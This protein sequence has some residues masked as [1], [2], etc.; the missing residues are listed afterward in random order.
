MTV[1]SPPPSPTN[2]MFS[3]V[4]LRNMLQWLPGNGTPADTHYTV[5]YA[6]YGDSAEDG[7]G[8]RVHWR[9]VRQC[10]EI[11]RSWCDLSNETWDLEHGYYARIRAVSKRA[12]SK[13]TLTR[14]FDPKLDTTFGPPLISVEIESN[15]ATVT[16]EGPMRYQPNNHTPGVSMATLY[17]QMMYNLSI[18]NKYR[19]QMSHFLMISS[20]YKYKLMEYNTEYCFSAKT[21]FLSLPVHCGSSAWHCITTPP[22]PL[23]DH[24]KW[25]VVGIIVPFT[26]M[27]VL[28]VAS[29]LLYHYLSGKGQKSPNN[30][31]P[32]T[33]HGPPLTFPPE[34]PNFILITVM[35][36]SDTEGGLSDPVFPKQQRQIAGPALSYVPQGSESP[37]E[38]EESCDDVS[39]DYGFVAEAL[40]IHVRGGEE[41]RRWRHDG[42]DWNN[43]IGEN[44]SGV[45]RDRNEEK[46]QKVGSA[47][48]SQAQ[49]Y[50]S[51]RSGHT[52]T[53]THMLRDKQT[54][55]STLIRAQVFSD[56]APL[57]QTQEPFPSFQGEED[58]EKKDVDFP[59]LFSNKKPQI[60]SFHIPLNLQT[61]TEGGMNDETDRR[62]RGR[63]D[64]EIDGGVEERSEGEGV[65]LLSAYASQN[66]RDM[67]AFQSDLPP[68]DYGGLRLATADEIDYGDDDNEEE[69]E[70]WGGGIFIDWG[71]NMNKLVFKTAGSNEEEGTMGQREEDEAYE[72]RGKLTLENVFV[73]QASEEEAEAQRRL[74]RGGD[75][76]I[77]TKWN[78]VIP[79]D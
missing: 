53:Q 61:E 30:L 2:V 15:S 38:P 46:V 10:T 44:Q 56:P 45:A 72:K 8:R 17:P 77:F 48:A 75:E 57:T 66:I 37:P 42:E 6:I 3:S 68:N 31:N 34:K 23:I 13:W 70:E 76:D 43:P 19:D 21:K 7:K 69:E 27:C 16:L 24:L 9:A 49:C 63:A 79:T 55:I 73:R 41:G 58:E 47:R 18:H 51:Q 5:Q 40:N 11:T 12:S 26:C 59:G 35:Q 14:R 33:C 50:L 4:N 64:G 54:E 36:P 78:L 74:D 39:V 60:D 62:V 71:P 32:P 52:N 67:P 25:V 22:D 65:P 28:V 1:S 29:Y 20:P